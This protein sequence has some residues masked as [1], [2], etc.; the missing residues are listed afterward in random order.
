MSVRLVAIRKEKGHRPVAIAEIY[1]RLITKVLA[2]EAR[3]YIKLATGSIQ[4]NGLSSACEAAH[5][6][7][8]ALYKE[9]K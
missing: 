8:D 3:P 1:R 5:E 7:V 2:K 4:C 6:N 9:G